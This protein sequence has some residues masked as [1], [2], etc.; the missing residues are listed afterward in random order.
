MRNWFKRSRILWP[1][2]T[3]QMKSRDLV[4]ARANDGTFHPVCNFCGG[5]CGQCGVTWIVGNVPASMDR[6]ISNLGGK[7]QR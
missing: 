5:N 7:V 2:V 3:E 1:E 4:W 6:M